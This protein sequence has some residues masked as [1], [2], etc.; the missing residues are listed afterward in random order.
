MA[1]HTHMRVLF[2]PMRQG[3]AIFVKYFLHARLCLISDIMEAQ[4]E[5]KREA[6]PESAIPQLTEPALQFGAHDNTWG[7]Y[8]IYTAPVQFT[9]V[10]G[11]KVDTAYKAIFKSNRLIAIMSKRYQLL[12]NERALEMAN[13]IATKIGFKQ[14]EVY[15]SRDGNYMNATFLSSSN[16]G[17]TRDVNENTSETT[18]KLTSQDRVSLTLAKVGETAGKEREDYTFNQSHEHKIDEVYF[19]F[20]VYNSIDGSSGFGMGS[21]GASKVGY[22]A[23]EHRGFGFRLFTLRKVCMNGAIVR[24]SLFANET[25]ITNWRQKVETKLIEMPKI[26]ASVRHLANNEQTFMERISSSMSYLERH[27]DALADIYHRWTSIQ[28]DRDFAERL[29]ELPQKYLP[30]TIE[31]ENGKL[32]DDELYKSLTVW[33]AFNEVTAKVW[34]NEEIDIR[35]KAEITD[36]LHQALYRPMTATAGAKAPTSQ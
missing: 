22:D 8:D 12:P 31:V 16:N 11:K 36:K 6:A 9:D 4:T 33:E 21:K 23:G 17:Y 7:Q 14:H 10:V 29:I 25:T 3:E 32:T 34:H 13:E 1:V 28:M 35:R 15:Y 30:E 24:S 26:R 18:G 20:S 5:M 2:Q 19:G 27:L